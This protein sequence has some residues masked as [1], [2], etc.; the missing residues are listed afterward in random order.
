M[1]VGAAA[2]PAQDTIVGG[3]LM[4]LEW[5]R[6]GSLSAGIYG[7]VVADELTGEGEA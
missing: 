2:E 1:L 4:V 7:S 5:A 3:V 6:F